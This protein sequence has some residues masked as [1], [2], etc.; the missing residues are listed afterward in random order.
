[1]NENL[2]IT[3]ITTACI[4]AG[5]LVAF[6]SSYMTTRNKEYDKNRQQFDILGRKLTLFRQM[7]GFV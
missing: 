2:C 3:I 6:L 4:F 1:M 5:F 7:C